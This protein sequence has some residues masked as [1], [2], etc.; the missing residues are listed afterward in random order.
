MAI[1]KVKFAPGEHYHLC[2]RG[3]GKKKIFLEER[4]FIRFLFLILHFQSSMKFFHIERQVSHFVRSKAFN[5]GEEEIKNII[6]ARE[7]ILEGFAIMENHLHISLQ[8]KKQRGT[9]NYMQRVLTSYAKYSNAKYKQTGHVFEGT[10]RAVHIKSNEQLLYLSAYIH[11][12]PREIVGWKE[13]E[14]RYPWSSYQDCLGGN[15]W[16]ELLDPSIVLNQFSGPSPYREF[17]ENSGAKEHRPSGFDEVL[18]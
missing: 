16:G 1:R 11:R 2:A 14:H 8:E 9:S 12:N 4:D 5:I 13:K 17:V 7:V 6:S 15:R 10:F 18:E 3:V